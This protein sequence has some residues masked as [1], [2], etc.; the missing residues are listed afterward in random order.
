MSNSQKVAILGASDKTDRYAYKAFLMLRENGHEVFPVNPRIQTID[1]VKVYAAL[2]DL[3]D[4]IDTLTLY[5]AEDKLLPMVDD[6]IKLRPKR[7]IFNPGTESKILQ[8]KLIEAKI[9]FEEA[10]TLVLLS[11]GQFDLDKQP[12]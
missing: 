11:S 1:K 5:L 2:A 12:V 7:V 4:K 8:D 3:K 6:I 10:C 9:N